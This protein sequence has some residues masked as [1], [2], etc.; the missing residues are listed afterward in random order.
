MLETKALTGCV[1]G[2]DSTAFV[3]AK[4]REFV[5]L[6]V[7]LGRHNTRHALVYKRPY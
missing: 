1:R 2:S 6:R 7:A 4:A 5:S 3:A